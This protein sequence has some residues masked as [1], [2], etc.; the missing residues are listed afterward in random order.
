MAGR[1]LIADELATNRIAL[2]ARLSA[3]AYTVSIAENGS[4]AI[5]KARH[6]AHDL[7]LISGTLGDI[8]PC[9]LIRELRRSDAT[10]RTPILLLSPP[11]DRLALLSCLEAGADAVL[12][13]PL[14]FLVL[15]ARIRNLM[16][17][18]A[19]E[20]DLARNEAAAGSYGFSEA[21]QD[22]PTPRRV[23]LVAP[24]LATGGRWRRALTPLIRDR[25]EVLGSTGALSALTRQPAPDAIVIGDDPRNPGA[26][27]RLLSD[28]RCR[29]ETLHSAILVVQD[30]PDAESTVMAL[31]LG[32]SDLV[33]T[34]FDAAEVALRL[35]RELVR[36]SRADQCRAALRDGMRLA[37]TD[38]L[39]GLSNRRHALTALA[40]IA[41]EAARTG[42]GF[43][44]MVLDLDR[45]KRIN[46]LYGHAAGDSVLTEVAVRMT[47]CLRGGDLL[48]RI[49][50]E[51]F[52]VAVRDCDLSRAMATAERMRRAIANDPIALPGGMQS[53]RVTTSI[54]LVMAGPE[55]EDA[56]VLIDRADRA[57]FAAKSEGRNQVTISR[58]AA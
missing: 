31:D 7:I 9:S 32:A 25:I 46:D 18:H 56:Q 39:T 38:P 17:R 28:L 27:A 49:G 40:R 43:A 54:G 14:D 10:A 42:S 58:S 57:L 3:A 5:E 12:R 4:A 48:A 52:L 35:R 24:D 15:R 45:F 16:R 2:R 26:A 22:F 53:V 23:A 41:A 19:A 6:T 50:G 30:A 13:R 55:P 11:A 29:G 51:E 44:V 33:D 20:T 1:I 37:A 34:G 8:D 36:K 47:A 21:P